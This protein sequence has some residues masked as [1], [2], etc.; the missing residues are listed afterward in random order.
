M[1]E[2]TPSLGRLIEQLCKLPGIGRKTATRLAFFVLQQP[3]HDVTELAQALRDVKHNVHLC[4]RCFNIT[5]SD[6]CP[7]C[8]A[9]ERDTAM[10]CVV[11]Q[12]QDLLA[13]ER[14]HDYHG[15]YHVLHGVLS[16]LDGIG[17][18]DLRIPHLL[19]RLGQ[20]GVEEVLVAT[21]FSME[22]EA[23]A[24]YL[25]KIIHPLGIKVSR[26]A[27]GI[28]MGGDLEYLDAATLSGAIARRQQM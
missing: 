5:E 10:I 23:T 24:L 22:G 6:P 11:E 25:S 2:S 19:E 28:P 13:I 4:T 18:D 9:P 14:G 15:L 1:L 26:L 12:P 20:G 21:N 8:R 16:P 27:H 3:Q 7:I 17:P